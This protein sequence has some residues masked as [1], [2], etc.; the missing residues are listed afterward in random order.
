MFLI[1]KLPGSCS[2]KKVNLDEDTLKV[3]EKFCNLG[4]VLSTDG[5]MHDSVVTK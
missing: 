3:V 5:R 4:D 2:E 1:Q